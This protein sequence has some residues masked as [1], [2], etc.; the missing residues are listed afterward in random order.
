MILY[1]SFTL[2]QI[3]HSEIPQPSLLQSITVD[4]LQRKKISLT[5]QSIVHMCFLRVYKDMELIY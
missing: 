3:C 1:V 2:I 5:Y 4:T